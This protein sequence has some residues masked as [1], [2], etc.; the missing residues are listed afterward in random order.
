MK[1]NIGTPGRILRLTIALLLF[2][3][4]LYKTSWIL[5]TLG[6]FVLYE[7]IA[8][9]CLFYQLIGKNSCPK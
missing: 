6:L 3:L 8:S 4:A 1:K 7:A 2:A 5:A 9:W